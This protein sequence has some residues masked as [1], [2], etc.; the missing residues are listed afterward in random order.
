M[1]PPATQLLFSPAE[2]PTGDC[3]L[4]EPIE[5]RM[6]A[7]YLSSR[8]W[9]G[10]RVA[11]HVR[12]GWP[13]GVD[14]SSADATFQRNLRL[15]TLKAADAI[16]ARADQATIF[17]FAVWRPQA[18]LSQLMT[19]R[20]LLPETPGYEGVDPAKI[21]A[22]LVVGVSDRDVAIGARDMGVELEE[23]RPAWLEAALA[24]RRG[25]SPP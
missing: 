6:M 21:R 20:R 5:E 1:R 17:E 13:I 14:R 25:S 22:V 10:A 18:K 24:K 23:Y 3:R 4:G 2:I 15:V 16:V 7:E 19:Y 9:G 12:L 8:D 11:T